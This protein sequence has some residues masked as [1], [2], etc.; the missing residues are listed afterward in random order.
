MSDATEVPATQDD[1]TADLARGLL[2]IAD[3]GGMPDTFWRTD[4]RVRLA[5][6]VL[7]I[8]EDGRYTHAH[9]W[10]E[11]DED[12]AVDELFWHDSG[13]RA[14]PRPQLHDGADDY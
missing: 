10:A 13:S 14:H 2:Q 12:Q 8:P 5:R 9:L 3:A 6:E 4:S 1:R 11:A 7:G